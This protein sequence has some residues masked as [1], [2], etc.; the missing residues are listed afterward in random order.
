[1]S[2][3]SGKVEEK[4]FKFA[5]DIVQLVAS[6]PSGEIRSILGKQLMRSGT[7]IGANIEEARGGISKPDFI[8]SMNVA[9]KEARESLYWLRLLSEFDSKNNEKLTQLAAECDELIRM[10][11]AIVKTSQGR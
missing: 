9:K 1:M 11:S 7:S 10:L 3:K 8:H 2:E 5:K 4:A 6:L